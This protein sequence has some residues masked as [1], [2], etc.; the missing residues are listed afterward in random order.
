MPK[1]KNLAGSR[2][3]KL[4]VVWVN[5]ELGYSPENCKWATYKEQATNRR[6]KK[7]Q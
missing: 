1:L 2:F 7:G 6:P 4:T 3:G 5:N